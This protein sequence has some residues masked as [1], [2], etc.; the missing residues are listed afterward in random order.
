MHD[1]PLKRSAGC[2]VFCDCAYDTS[3]HFGV[4]IDMRSFLV[5]PNVVG[6]SGERK[7]LAQFTV[8]DIKDSVCNHKQ[9]LISCRYWVEIANDHMQT[10]NLQL[11][12]LD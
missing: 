4:P 12:E 9:T 6:K 3:E 5:A 8:K 2:K 10:L 7:G 11:V 1:E